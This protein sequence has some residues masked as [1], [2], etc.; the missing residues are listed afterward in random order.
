MSAY[1]L[2]FR[3]H[4]LRV[5]V[6]YPKLWGSVTDQ[7]GQQTIDVNRAVVYSAV[8]GLIGTRVMQ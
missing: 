4:A 1:D 3:Y 2:C 8:V 5:V 6:V 7:C